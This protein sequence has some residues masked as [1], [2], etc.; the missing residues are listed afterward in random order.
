MMKNKEYNIVEYDITTDENFMRELYPV[1][2]ELEAQLENLYMLAIKGKKSGIKKLTNYILKYPRVPALKNY[3]SVLYNSLNRPDKAYEVNHW[4]VAEHPEYLFGKLNLATEYF[5]K[6]EFHKMPEILGE[7][8]ELKLLYPQRNTFHIVEVTGFL[9]IAVLYFSAIG[10]LEQAETRLDILKDI[11]PDSEDLQAAQQHYDRALLQQPFLRKQ[12]IQENVV[13]VSIKNT[14]L[15]NIETPPE[16]S[17]KQIYLL[18]ENDYSI[19]NKIVSDLLKLPRKSLI[20]DLNKVLKDSITRYN[21]FKKKAENG[22]FEDKTSSFLTHALF[23]L[24]EINASESLANVLE[25]LSQEEEYIELYLDEVLTE[26]IWLVLYKISSADLPACK[27]FMLKPGIYTYSKSEV[28]EMIN[29]V[30]LHEPARRE[31]VIIWFRDVLR[32]YN[33]ASLK[34][35]IIDSTLLGMLVNC[36]LD[37]NGAELLPEIENLYDKEIVDL[38][39][40]GDIEEVKDHFTKDKSNN[41]I[42]EISSIFGIYEEIR[43]WGSVSNS[44]DYSFDETD[45]RDIQPLDTT[46]KIGRNDLC[47]CGSGKK[48]KK[49][50]LNK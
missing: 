50:C 44:T 15:T 12:A 34:D 17:N 3:L 18:Y 8:M 48:Y 32:F 24:A 38:D 19:D 25:V 46:P 28:V 11:D 47:P 2:Y 21:Y 35:N 37:F 40:C 31:E 10:D 22:Q 45:F 27:K 5:F 42:R 49:C 26:Y 4:I 41:Y 9:K 29:Q 23:L 20:D 7:G 33:N 43:S 16:F 30:A 13:N 6:E 1:P 36:V 39:S 14:I